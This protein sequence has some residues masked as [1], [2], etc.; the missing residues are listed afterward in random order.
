MP[1]YWVTGVKLRGGQWQFEHRSEAKPEKGETLSNR[2]SEKAP[3]T[4]YRV[5]RVIEARPIR[6]I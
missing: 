3:L 6:P 1:V 5:T 4:F 2:A